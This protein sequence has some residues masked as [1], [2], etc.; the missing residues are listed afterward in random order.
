[1]SCDRS[2]AGLR[3]F[4]KEFVLYFFASLLALC[5]DVAIFSISYRLFDL[6]LPIAVILGYLSG[7]LLLY[8]MSVKYVFLARPMDDAPASEFALFIMLGLVGLM[9]TQ[10]ILYVGVNM[11]HLQPEAVKLGAAASSFVMNFILRKFFIFWGVR[12]YVKG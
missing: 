1:M 12:A 3:F 2:E 9:V 8:I 6:Y 10:V 7:A 4:C 5:L 11:L